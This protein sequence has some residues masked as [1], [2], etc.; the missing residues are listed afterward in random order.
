MIPDRRLLRAKNQQLRSNIGGLLHQNLH[1]C[2]LA[3]K[4]KWLQLFSLEINLLYI[5]TTTKGQL[6]YQRT[7]SSMHA[8]AIKYHFIRHFYTLQLNQP[9][10]DSPDLIPSN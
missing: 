5:L 6:H 4:L 7:L 3:Q 10:T 2:D 1:I 9:P 8:K